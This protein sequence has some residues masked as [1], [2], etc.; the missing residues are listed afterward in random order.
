MEQFIFTMN[1]KA[2]LWTFILKILT[3]P[4]TYTYTKSN[5]SQKM[6]PPTVRKK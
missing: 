5:E 2:F 1:L 4:N 6:S 3:G